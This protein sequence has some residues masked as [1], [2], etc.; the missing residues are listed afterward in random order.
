[1]TTALLVVAG[2]GALSALFV[3]GVRALN[4]AERKV[5]QILREELDDPDPFNTRL[6]PEYRTPPTDTGE[7]R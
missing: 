1:M 5:D 6:R 2:L 4:R 3:I 7:T